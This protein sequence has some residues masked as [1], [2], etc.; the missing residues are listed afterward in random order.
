M[1]AIARAIDVGYGYTKYSFAAQDGEIR[2]GL[3]PSIS[4]WN[5]RDPTKAVI[6]ERRDTVC[7]R[8]DGMYHEVGPGIAAARGRHRATNMHDGYI[9]TSEYQAF[10]KA[11]LHY[12][13]EDRIDVLVM[14]LPVSH[15]LAK[16]CALERAWTGEHELADGKRIVVEQVKVF[17]QPQGALASYGVASGHES[18]RKGEL[19]LVIDPGQRTFDWLVSRGMV[20]IQGQS[21][22]TNRGMHDILSAICSAISNELGEEYRDYDAVETALRHKK[23]LVL[24]QTPYE[25]KRFRPIIDQVTREA[26]A[27]L[28]ECVQDVASIQNIVLV[29]GA[30][31]FFRPAVKEAFRRH[32]ITDVADPVFANVRGFQVIAEEILQQRRRRVAAEQQP[33]TCAA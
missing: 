25:L 22:S 21:A 30:A 4:A 2:Y 9:D 23:P 31:P 10:V 26:L 7:V 1:P 28:L 29:G 14:G 18:V 6:G 15:L 19:N 12:M 8:I 5:T 13:K 27:Q 20:L 11:A 32:R 33:G 24:Y 3:F 17:A 16:R